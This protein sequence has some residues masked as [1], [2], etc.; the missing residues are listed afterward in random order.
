MCMCVCMY[1]GAYIHRYVYLDMCRRQETTTV[2]LLRCL[3][4]LLFALFLKQGE[5]LAWKFAKQTALTGQQAPGVNPLLP[6]QCSNY[7]TMAPRGDFSAWVLWL[8]S[9]LVCILS[10][11]PTELFLQ[12]VFVLRHVSGSSNWPWTCYDLEK[13]ELLIL[14]SHLLSAEVTGVH[15]H[16]QY[17]TPGIEPRT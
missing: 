14:L 6:T 12:T 17:L 9:G 16:T 15:H 2:L 3:V 4:F 1:V 13:L 10:I 8:N 5:S 7:E 11:L